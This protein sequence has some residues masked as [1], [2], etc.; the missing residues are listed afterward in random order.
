MAMIILVSNAHTHG[1]Q[2]ALAA[3]SKGFFVQTPQLDIAIP[4]VVFSKLLL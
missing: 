2:Q 4:A 3:P 1:M